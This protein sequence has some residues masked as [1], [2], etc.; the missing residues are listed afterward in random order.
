MRGLRL[1]R[2]QLERREGVL[3][4]GSRSLERRVRA[5]EAECAKLV[6]QLEQLRAHLVQVSER[7]FTC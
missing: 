6:K 3:K 1:E 7:S 5:K 2:D 4:E